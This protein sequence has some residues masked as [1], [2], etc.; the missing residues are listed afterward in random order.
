LLFFAGLSSVMKSESL[1]DIHLDAW[2]S[3]PII[4]ESESKAYECG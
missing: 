1:L 2:L 3:T 4:C